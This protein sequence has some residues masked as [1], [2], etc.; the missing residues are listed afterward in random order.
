MATWTATL[1][2]CC[3]RLFLLV[4]QSDQAKRQHCQLERLSALSVFNLHDVNELASSSPPQTGPVAV[5]GQS[6]AVPHRLSDSMSLKTELRDSPAGVHCTC[7]RK[8]SVHN[9]VHMAP[10][11]HMCTQW[12]TV[13]YMQ[14][15]HLRSHLHQHTAGALLL[16]RR[17]YWAL[18]GHFCDFQGRTG[19]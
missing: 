17:G 9:V 14:P 6:T 4:V 11:L 19:Q 15:R 5:V 13:Q 2:P 18:A 3:M 1:G 12:H 10:A 7:S 8:M 16:P